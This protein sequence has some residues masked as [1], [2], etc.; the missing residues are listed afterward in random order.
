MYFDDSVY[1][2]LPQPLLDRVLRIRALVDH[3]TEDLTAALGHIDA[4]SQMSPRL[5]KGK[6]KG[7]PPTPTDSTNVSQTDL[8]HSCPNLPTQ[9]D[10]TTA[11]QDTTTTTT[12]PPTTPDFPHTIHTSPAPIL[13]DNIKRFAPAPRP[14]PYYTCTR[15]A[16]SCVSPPRPI[17]LFPSPPPRTTPQQCDPTQVYS[18]RIPLRGT[19]TLTPAGPITA[20]P[21][22]PQPAST[23]QPFTL[24][25]TMPNIRPNHPEAS[26]GPEGPWWDAT[27]SAP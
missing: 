26:A 22:A 23:A 21:H 20:I 17:N 16:N 14:H 10:M 7:V 19:A 1:P 25:S 2:H 27:G 13:T 5:L 18:L 15:S 6:G 3:A 11:P 4:I 8:I 24:P 12:Q 9:S